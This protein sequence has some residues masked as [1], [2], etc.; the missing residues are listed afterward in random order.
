MRQTTC[1]LTSLSISLAKT[2][3]TLLALTALLAFEPGLANVKPAHAAECSSNPAQGVDWTGCRKRNLMLDGSNLNGAKLGE[4]DF[5]STD[6]RNL[7]AEGADFSKSTLV[8]SML[9]ST[10]GKNSNFE[11]AVGF[12]T[13]FVGAD[14]S[15]SRFDKSEMQRA[16]F[17]KADLTGVSFEK[18]ELGRALFE[19]AKLTGGN[20]RF[21]NLARADL[22][23]AIID[24]PLDFTGAYFYRT[25][26]DGVDL[27]AAAGLLQWQ[28]DLSCGDASTKLPAG[29]TASAGWPCEDE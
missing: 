24:T 23:G 28:I 7:S 12:R 25:R 17:T 20:F 16:D 13:S 26:L 10:K 19:G 8:R 14:L 18:S 15:G 3:A 1:S 27:S 2:P 22:R 9:D 6:L 21:A 4:A 11:K 5:T 29:L